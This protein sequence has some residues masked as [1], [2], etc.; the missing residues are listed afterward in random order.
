ME[1]SF[2]NDVVAHFCAGRGT[3]MDHNAAT[4]AI[5]KKEGKKKSKIVLLSIAALSILKS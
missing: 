5:K 4:F 1:Q 3:Y 2:C